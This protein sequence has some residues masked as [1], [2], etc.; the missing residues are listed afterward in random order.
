VAKWWPDAWPGVTCLETI[1]PSKITDR[2]PDWKAKLQA[3][4]DALPD[5][6]IC[7]YDI[8]WAWTPVLLRWGVGTLILDEAHILSGFQSR[9]AGVLK[10]L[11]AVTPRRI[12]LT[13][14]PVTNA[15]RNLHNV[16]EILAP[17]RFG[18]F[19]TGARP[20]CFSK[21]YCAAFQ[22][23][24]GAGFESKTVWDFSGRSNLD[25]A[26]G[27]ACLTQEETLAAR[28]K[29]LMLR[30]LKRDVDKDLPV[31]T[32]QVVDVTVPARAVVGV[33]RLGTNGEE[34]RRCL[35]LAAD[36]KLPQVIALVKGHLDEEEKV[37]C[38]CYRRL[39]AE[40]IADK[41]SSHYETTFVH[42]GLSQRERDKRI[43]A[44]RAAPGPGVLACTIDTT[45]TGID[46]SF[47]S[48]AVFGE[49]TWEPH[50]L[51]QAEERLYRYGDAAQRSLIQ[52]VI[53]RGTGDELILRAV[54][55]KLDTFER[56]VGEPGDALKDDLSVRE[57]GL[58]R[59]Y[60][61]LRA[62][63]AP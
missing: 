49:L 38:F 60:K 63:G 28:M 51:A 18:Y 19:F 14:T 61:A 13:G 59:L 53:A 6:V 40:Q 47:A 11:A 43:H 23:Q 57:K 33:S 45:S 26:D 7:H 48:V 41:L 52:Y 1:A 39:F 56:V 31:K 30:R 54:V 16:L 12:A 3:L 35:D 20:G 8:L 62:M 32:R 15:P 37:I 5:V 21:V 22:K 24:V 27:V 55:L 25:K 2:A 44:L 9:R 4:A 29:Y 46:L 42:G 10:E 50:E 58:D 17:G 34:L 36:A